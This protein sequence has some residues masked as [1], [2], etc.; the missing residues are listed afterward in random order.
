MTNS[1]WFGHSPSNCH[2]R[3]TWFRS[4]A[5]CRPLKATEGHFNTLRDALGDHDPEGALLHGM[6]REFRQRVTS[7]QPFFKSVCDWIGERVF[8]DQPLENSELAMARHHESMLIDLIQ[9]Q[10]QALQARH[11]ADAQ[12]PNGPHVMKRAVPLDFLQSFQYD[13]LSYPYRPVRCAP[14]VAAQISLDAQDIS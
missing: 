3:G 7:R 1:T 13:R 2:L 6:F 11:D 12:Y 4:P 9:Q 8:P 14:F 10:E 5:G